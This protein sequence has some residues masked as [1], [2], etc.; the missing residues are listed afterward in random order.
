MRQAHVQNGYDVPESSLQPT[1]SL[2]RARKTPIDRARKLPAVAVGSPTLVQSSILH[3]VSLPWKNLVKSGRCLV[4][5]FFF[6]IADD[7]PSRGSILLSRSLISSHRQRRKGKQSTALRLNGFWS[8]INVLSR[9]KL[10][11]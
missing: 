8:A 11:R 1:P 9:Q 6:S 7:S 5:L 2:D 4:E 10:Q 3:T